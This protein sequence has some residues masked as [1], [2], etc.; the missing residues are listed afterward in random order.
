MRA[1]HFKVLL[2]EPPFHDRIRSGIKRSTMRLKAACKPGERLSLRTWEGRPYESKQVQ[3]VP[4]FATCTAVTSIWL[5]IRDHS[6]LQFLIQDGE[7]NT[8]DSPDEGSLI[9]IAKLEG[10]DNLSD[11]SRWF[12]DS[13]PLLQTGAMKAHWIEWALGQTA[14]SAALLHQDGAQSLAQ[15]LIQQQRKN[16]T[17]EIED[18]V[19]RAQRTAEKVRN[20][21]AESIRMISEIKSATAPFQILSPQNSTCFVPPGTTFLREED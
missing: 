6:Q 21:I 11:M 10:F 9:D 4:E 13:Q 17:L 18:L 15:Q 8:W 1:S 3:L 19:N 2:F 16:L 20:L 7:L 12:M 5:G 14:N